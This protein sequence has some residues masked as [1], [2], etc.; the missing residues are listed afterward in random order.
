MNKNDDGFINLKTAQ[1]GTDFVGI[2]ITPQERTVTF[3][4]GYIPS[5]QKLNIS[6]I[7]K[8][9]RKEILNLLKLISKETSYKKGERISTLDGE[10]VN[11]FPLKAIV[12]IIEDF[13]DRNTY[14]TEKETLYSKNTFGKINWS[15]TIK[16]IKPVITESG[17]AFLDFIVRKNR[18]QENQ[19]ITELHKYCV[20]KSFELLGFLYTPSMP[21]KG[22]L[23]ESDISKNKK[24]YSD[25]IQEKID[26]T[27]LEIN[28]ELFSAM[29]DFIN[30]FDSVNENNEA[31]YGT[32]CFQVVWENLIDKIFGTVD[33]KTME[34]YFYPSSKWIFTED[35]KMKNNHPLKPDSIMITENQKCFILD[36]KYYSYDMLRELEN[37][38]NEEKS[39]LVHGSI[40][41][42]DSIQKQI[43]Y[44]QYVDKDL[45]NKNFGKMEY[46]FSENDIFNIF[47]LPT[48]NSLD[49]LKYIGYA[50][51]DWQENN[52]NYHFVHAVTFDTKTAMELA[53]KDTKVFKAELEKLLISKQKEFIKI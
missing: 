20:Y 32:Y 41:G 8:S 21:E 44:A 50:T 27:H 9:K 12:F 36:S 35:K 6:K 26:N 48:N 34:K 1:N 33:S 13:L 43:T 4:M 37:D 28:L 5:E 18:I 39:I 16:N 40:P 42:T 52:K 25:F 15:K 2:R 17:I 46:R 14:Y 53:E 3:P 19:L 45:K 51:S 23:L 49:K 38:E 30:N 31:S 24:Y 22:L 10:K 47:I 7:E 29:L 11:D